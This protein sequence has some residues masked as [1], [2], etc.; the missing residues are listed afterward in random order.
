MS[1]GYPVVNQGLDPGD[2]QPLDIVEISNP[3]TYVSAVG[4]TTGADI[5]LGNPGGAGNKIVALMVFNN[6]GS[7]FT[8][9][10]LKDGTTTLTFL[11]LGMTTLASGSYA[12]WTPPG[13]ALESKNGAWRINITCAGTMAN[14]AIGAV[15][16][17]G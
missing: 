17:E 5:V 3:G 12:T 1:G 11:T 8:A 6:S 10:T 4:V 15:I 2:N 16:L 14:I 7:A 9:C 13:G